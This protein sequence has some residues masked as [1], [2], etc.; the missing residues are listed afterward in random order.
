MWFYLKSANNMNPKNKVQWIPKIKCTHLG[1]T[2][3]SICSFSQIIF[4]H[5]QGS[6]TIPTTQH[7]TVCHWKNFSKS[8]L[9][10]ILLDRGIESGGE[11]SECWAVGI[12]FM[13]TH[14]SST[15]ISGHTNPL[16]PSEKLFGSLDAP[17]HCYPTIPC[18]PSQIGS[19][20]INE[21]ISRN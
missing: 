18:P 5:Q 9:S 1:P 6:K 8:G 13:F 2:L 21:Q 15:T 4:T 3:I 11:S 17:P 10:E 12:N 14:P 16:C 7:L 20:S 19:S